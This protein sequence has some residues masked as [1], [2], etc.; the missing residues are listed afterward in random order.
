MRLIDDLRVP[1]AR[2]AM[3]AFVAP[4]YEQKWQSH[5]FSVCQIL[6]DRSIPVLLIDNV[7]DYYYTASDQE[8]WDLRRDFP[9]LAPPYPQFWAEHK[10]PR[11]IHS[12]EKGDTKVSEMTSG[13]FGVLITAVVREDAQGEGIPE[14]VKWILWCEVFMDYNQRGVTAVGSNGAIFVAIDAEGRVVETPWM[15]SFASHVDDVVMQGLIAWV[16]PVFLAVSFMHC[17]NVRIDENRPPKP[18]AAKYRKRTGIDPTPYRTLV[19]EPLK[20]ILK[21]EGGHGSGNGLA[22][23]MHICRGHFRD[24]REG[25]GLF[26]KYKQLVWMPSVIR[27]TKG[28]EAPPREVEVKI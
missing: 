4:H 9:N 21:S 16:N 6:Q 10:L 14:N 13:R 23:A 2:V 27:G 22:K 3:P 26:G 20:Q 15:Q 7:S 24:Y 28:K 19:I 18:L 1:G 25:R 5:T 17:R 11:T 8:H 12:A